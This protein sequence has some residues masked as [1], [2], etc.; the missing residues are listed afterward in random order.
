MDGLPTAFPTLMSR[1][2]TLMAAAA[3]IRGSW[4]KKHNRQLNRSVSRPPRSGAMSDAVASVAAPMPAFVER[5]R[6]GDMS[7]MLLI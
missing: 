7:M 6:S 3:D 2:E 4:I 5:F 1:K